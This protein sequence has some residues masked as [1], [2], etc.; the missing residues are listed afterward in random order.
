MTTLNDLNTMALVKQPY[1]ITVARHNFDV[2]EMRIM[3]RI[4]QALQKDM[5][6][7]KSRSE[8]KNI[9]VCDKAIHLKT[10]SLLPV[11]SKNYGRVRKALKTLKQ[12]T[13]TVYGKDKYG[14]YETHV[15]LILRSKYYLN[16]EMVEIEIDKNILPDYLAL[17]SY[18]TYIAEVSMAS[19]SQYVM[20]LYQFISHWKDKYDLKI[21]ISDLRDL[22]ELG[23][24]YKNSKDVR[25]H[26]LE[27]TIIDLKERADV[28]FDITSPIKDGRSVIGWNIRIYQR[29]NNLRN[30]DA[31]Q[32]NI[33]NALKEL[34]KLTEY[35]FKKLE[36]IIN[37]PAMHRHIYR[38]IDDIRYQLEKKQV[39]HVQAYV[40]AALKDE[41]EKRDVN[42]YVTK[43][44][45][46]KLPNKEADTEPKNTPE[47]SEN[48][49]KRECFD[50][51]FIDFNID[52]LIISGIVSRIPP[53]Q[54]KSK[55]D[56]L[57]AE[58]RQKGLS[59][60][61]LE[62]QEYLLKRLGEKNG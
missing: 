30:S 36:N 25:K 43:K 37:N 45:L 8:L 17:A 54:L 34:F 1:A 3:T 23:D 5:I 35:H 38:K 44:G 46:E 15:S 39:K 4:T 9:M 2:H 12:K 31:H 6:Y 61:D 58:L 24:K 59:P 51:I 28:W 52:P 56:N 14:D 32:I 60:S 26:I 18:S 50:R 29:N 21:M 20:R 57:D 22:L 13:V 27:P 11:G 62:A 10:K 47:T 53:R 19:S 16:N 7:G 33:I 40:V 42:I 48:I 49:L 41:F 55:I